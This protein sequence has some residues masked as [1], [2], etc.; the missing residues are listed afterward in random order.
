MAQAEAEY[1]GRLTKVLTD[2]VEG[3][4][5]YTELFQKLT[6]PNGAIKV[7]CQVAEL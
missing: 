4:E 7:F 6:S 3:L 5:N 1:P 2:P